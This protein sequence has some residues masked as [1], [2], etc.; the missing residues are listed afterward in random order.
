[1]GRI[2]DL[3][4][5]IFDCIGC[6]AG[7]A[8]A[9]SP[10]HTVQHRVHPPATPR[11]RRHFRFALPL[12]STHDFLLKR[13]GFRFPLAER[14]TATPN[15]PRTRRVSRVAV[16]RGVRRRHSRFALPLPSIHYFLLKRKGFRFPLAACPFSRFALPL[17]PL[18]PP[19]R[20]L[21]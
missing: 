11:R 12:P 16:A 9:P 1:M 2:Y 13:K 6:E 3:R 10:S 19:L 7:V 15:I 8:T 14:P 21:R 5:T 4:F 20:P 17:R 18:R